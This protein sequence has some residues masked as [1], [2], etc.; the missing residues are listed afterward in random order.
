MKLALLVGVA[1]V[2]GTALVGYGPAERRINAG[3]STGSPRYL[4]YVE[5]ETTLVAPPVAGRLVAR[6]VERGDRVKKGDR[7]FVI[8]TTQAEAE[9]ARAVAVLAEFKARHANLLTGKRAEEQEVVRAQRREIE[10]NLVMAEADLARQ[11][12]LLAKRITSRQSYDQSVAQVAELRARMASMRARERA[13]DLSA[14]QPEIDAAAALVEQQEAI[15][16]RA[17]NQLADLMP[18]APDDGLVEN[19]FFNV[20][21]WVPPGSPVVSLL[22]D[23]RIKLRFFVPEGELAKART[24]MRVRFS[25]DGCTPDL[26]A[27]VTYI[28]PRAEYTPP[29]IYSQGTRAKLVFMV[30]AQPGL[31]DAQRLHPGQ[32]LEVRLVGKAAGRTP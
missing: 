15:L 23:F 26:G 19:T 28:S 2:A 3:A 31:T 4:G 25:C 11:T 24:A 32:P 21:E 22:P 7:L 12:D 17:K 16:N 20:G 9:V 5:G 8:D 30:E 14:R 29:I 10:A 27:T 6:P 18:V 13:G 1:V